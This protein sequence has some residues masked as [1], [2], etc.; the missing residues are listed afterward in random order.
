MPKSRKSYTRDDGTVMVEIRTH[1]YVE[2]SIAERM[3]LLR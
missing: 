1:E 2:E 3:G